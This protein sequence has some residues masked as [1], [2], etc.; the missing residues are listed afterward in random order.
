MR[1]LLVWQADPLAAYSWMPPPAPNDIVV[2]FDALA[3]ADLHER[4]AQLSDA[5]ITWEQRSAAESQVSRLVA[6]LRDDEALA[7]LGL[8]GHRLTPFIE[9]RARA[10]F[11]HVL[12]GFAIGRA[13]HGCRAVVADPSI[14]DA[15][16]VGA[17]AGLGLDVGSAPYAPDEPAAMPAPLRRLWARSI[18]RTMAAATPTRGVRVAAVLTAKVA[19]SV[20]AL[21]RAQLRAAGLAAMPFPGLDYG[22]GARLAT[23][24]RIPLLATLDPLVAR[25]NTAPALPRAPDLGE[26]DSELSA[27]IGR[28]TWG[29]VESSWP[30]FVATA[31][32]VHALD[33]VSGL[34]ALLLPTTA[35]GASRMLIDWARRRG[36]AVAAVQHGVYGF[37]EHDGGDSRADVLFAWSERVREQASAWPQPRPRVVAVGVAGMAHASPR[38]PGDGRRLRV[39]V[40]T[41]GRPIESALAPTSFH[42]QFVVAITPGVRTLMDAGVGVQ[43]RLH[44][45]EN[46]EVYR[47]ILD[48]A[49]LRLPFAPSM[50]FP[51]AANQADLLVSAPSSVAFEAGALGVP[52]LMWNGGI[53]SAVRRAHLVAPL[54]LDLPGS[55]SDAPQ[56]DALV[57]DVLAEG[58]PAAGADLAAQLGSYATAFDPG[59][60]AQ[61]L[62][63]LAA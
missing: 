10:E 45:R 36:V 27:A 15:V 54:S 20:A 47:R 5:L 62:R 21:P 11:A 26:D 40:A 16:V 42:E 50:P 14:P 4:D 38:P 28:V 19:P 41:T 61:G 29:L 2:S 53:P 25:R 34:R 1:L 48:G 56:F 59:A 60:F 24:L 23:Q 12:R 58:A 9:Y 63:E 51:E 22:N 57:A 32:A 37:K 35:V 46:P 44:P 7:T 18:M 17:R 49:D 8:D 13:A 43:L 55:F 31:H 39:L 3:V 52:V 33:A 30:L 6:R